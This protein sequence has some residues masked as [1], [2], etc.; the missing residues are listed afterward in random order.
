MHLSVLSKSGEAVALTSTINMIFGSK[1][2]NN[3]TGIILNNQMDD[4]SVPGSPNGFHYEPSPY[5]FIYPFKRPQSSA[6][7]TIIEYEGRVVG[8]TGASG[9]SHII[10]AT[11][12]SIVRMFDME[13]DPYG[14]INAGRI[15]HQLFPNTAYVELSVPENIVSGLKKRRH[16]IK[17][18]TNAVGGSSV[19][20][21]KRLSDGL[22]VGSGDF[23]KNGSCV[24]Y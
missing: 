15:H 21:V 18:L 23:R 19:S 13:Q 1:I 24:A 11:A 10:S 8:I 14:A 7:P 16:V 22:F 17:D 5:N 12:Q 6:C 2:M 9:G 4:F 3:S 20:A